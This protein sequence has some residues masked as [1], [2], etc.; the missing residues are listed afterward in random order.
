LL[1]WPDGSFH[2][3]KPPRK[4][5]G[6]Y[7]LA[8]KSHKALKMTPSGDGIDVALPSKAPDPV[9]TVLVFKTRG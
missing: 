2:L 3:P 1:K 7:L 4:I 9:A 8:D 5:T 6:A